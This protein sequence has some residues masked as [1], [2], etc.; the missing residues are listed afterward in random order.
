[1]RDLITENFLDAYRSRG[2]EL[3]DFQKDAIAALA[4]G[5]DVLVC[6]PTG[7]GK[8]V[9]AQYAIELALAK[10]VRCIYT[11]PIK[12]LSN[13]KYREFAQL[14]GEETVGLLTG[15]T[16]VNR[17]AQILVVTTEVL[18]NML[19]QRDKG[20]QDI[21]YVVLDEVH[22]LS[23]K[24]RGPVWEE[25][26]LQ[27]PSHVRLVSLSATIA[28]IDEFSHW[29][30]SVRGKTTTITS[31]HR[32]V[33]LQQSLL[34]KAKITPILN[35]QGDLNDEA[36]AVI[37]ALNH[38]GAYSDGRRRARKVSLA[39]R[40]RVIAA[41]DER[42]YLPAI[43][44]I[45]SRK[46]CDNAVKD[47]LDADIVLTTAEQQKVIR[48][49]VKELR[50]TL[51]DDDARAV[52]FALWS[53]ALVRGFSA[54]HAGMFPAIKEL[55]ER[56]MVQG[57]LKLV[58]AT[59][60]LSLGIDMPVRAVV[61]EDLHKWNGSGFS[62]LT[63]TEY[64]QLIGRAGRRGK[65]ERGYAFVLA[66]ADID[67]GT[68]ERLA[69]GAMEPLE[70]AFYPS[71]NTVVS[72]L[73][74]HGRDE[75]RAIMGTSFA[76]FQKNADL[77]QI[78]GRIQRIQRRISELEGELEDR[79][80]GMDVVQYLQLRQQS[81][82]ASKAQR[83]AAKEEYRRVVEQSW[84][85]AKTGHLYA[86]ARD[87]ELE[88]GV[89]LSVSKTKIRLVNI[90]AEMVWLHS[91]EL[92]SEL[93]DLGTIKMPFGIS[94]KDLEVRE[95][96][97]QSILDAIDERS[98]L[99]TDRD[100]VDSWDRF[101]VRENS[102]LVAH[103]VHRHSK[104]KAILSDATE[105]LSLEAR[106]SELSALAESFEDSVAK[107]FD[108][109]ADILNYLGYLQDYSLAGGAHLLRGIHNE[110]DLLISMCLNEPSIAELTASEFAGI[111]SAFLG[112]RRL[113]KG[114]P[115]KAKL[116]AAWAAVERNYDYIFDIEQRFGIQRTIEP[117]PGGVEAFADWANGEKLDVV[118]TKSHIDVGD[119]ISASRRLLDLLGQLKVVG[120]DFWLG[121]LA[122]QAI[123]KIR[124]W[125]WL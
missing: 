65:D 106:L 47:L 99:G 54:H 83:K 118:L 33:P 60:T 85:N 14:L 102:D 30:R 50:E 57:L 80:P 40:K 77:G 68:L 28:N 37:S 88:Y 89:A 112:D 122:A 108:A 22:Y 26:I 62:D 78:Q 11:A 73:A 32:P 46:G 92:S 55:T 91:N 27:L 64:T 82:R 48:A 15:D 36:V 105:Y 41:L 120:S 63:A 114:F 58:Y 81:G 69:I 20:I 44:F 103:P 25:I 98:E 107:E 79:Y 42:D 3:D 113:G 1:M 97:A 16:V 100:L 93:R 61:V 43:E 31:F 111:C 17:D 49:Q 66:S 75:A 7:S 24:V 10:G 125:E 109:T 34:H 86:Y 35:N 96:I 9:I 56:L 4:S 87:G 45:F 51:S 117:D 59:G 12:A 123:A 104:H 74:I 70:S 76:Q 95:D 115:R 101:A 116:R 53:K 90:F 121:D 8:T 72:L 84:R 67:L 19:F 13:Q 21:G 39:Q 23:D 71:Y 38:R 2:I 119:F 6:A 52:R 110:S 18:R 94:P 124:R 29:L 5:S